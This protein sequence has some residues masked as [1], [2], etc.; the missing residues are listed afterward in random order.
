LDDLRHFES[1][2]DCMTKSELEQVL[3]ELMRYATDSESWER[4]VAIVER[5]IKELA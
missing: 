2:E 4:A 5:A 3:E 1:M